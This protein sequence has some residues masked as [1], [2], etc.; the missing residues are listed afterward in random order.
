MKRKTFIYTFV[1]GSGSLLFHGLKLNAANMKPGSTSI[2]MIYN[3]TGQYSGLK[4]AW[5]LSVWIEDETGVTLFDTGGDAAI[6]MKNMKHLGLDLKKIDRIAISHF[7]W[8]HKG[9]L[10]FV[11]GE[12]KENTDLYVPVQIKKKYQTEFPSANVIGV[13]KA[14]K[15]HNNIWSSGSL[16]TTYSGKDINE[17]SLVITEGDAMVIMNGCSHPGIVKIVKQAMEDHPDKRIS[18]VAGG[19][20]LMRTPDIEVRKISAELKELGIEKIAPSHC[21]GDKAIDIFRE[22]WGEQFVD[23]HIGD[24]QIC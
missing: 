23:M 21:T 7:H 12:T 15:I 4:N 17:Q 22:D 16:S 10:E 20:H 13:D 18:L 1:L 3:N 11:L 9:G 14:L 2:K 5:G 19:F 24:E 6:L 8:D